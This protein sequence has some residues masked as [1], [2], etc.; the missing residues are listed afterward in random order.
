MNAQA[1][2]TADPGLFAPG[3]RALVL[4]AL[5]L[6]SMIA[7]EA[8]AVAAVMPVV[9]QAL[10]GLD[11]F[12][13][14]FA[15]TAAL[16]MLGLVWAGADCD[17]QP[18]R[19]AMTAGLL[20]F[21]GGLLAAGMAADMA[22]LLV[23][24]LLQGLGAG[25]LGVAI[26]VVCGRLLPAPLRPRLLALFATAWVLPAIIGP[27]L[28]GLLVDALGWRSVFLAVALL[29]VPTALVLL[30][31]LWS[32]GPPQ[33][34]EGSRRSAPMGWAGAAASA[35][36]GLH[37]LRDLRS[38]GDG[39]LLMTALAMLWLAAR[40][41]LPNGTLRGGR[42]LPTVILLRGLLASAFFSAE[43]YLPLWLI[44]QHGW[45]VSAAGIALSLGALCW[46][47]G[48][49]LQVRVQAPARRLRWLRLGLLA[50]ALAGF[51]LTVMA[52]ANAP[53]WSVLPLWLLAGLGIGLAF[54][55]LSVLTLSY[56]PEHQQGS[57]S[58]ALQ[59]SDAL[60]CSAMLA[61]NG[62]AFA[63][64]HGHQPPLAFAAVFGLTCLLASAGALLAVRVQPAG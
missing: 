29:L 7:F 25:M 33:R 23:G 52:S 56:S 36:L 24:R 37:A 51:G 39:V 13:L 30:P 16:S 44:L 8:M 27:A 54:P 46:S 10:A 38:L 64:L 58:S 14:A 42:G 20:L 45:S 4:G 15:G 19:R 18:P 31:P 21:G 60:W 61:A 26:Y 50:V 62:A 55:M 28:A 57:N 12:A 11:H 48:S 17:R 63:L 1:L 41:L 53:A 59:L 43:V 40:R 6:L 49:H 34:P 35:A 32:L 3:R 22:W 47:V 5:A 2:A 9:A